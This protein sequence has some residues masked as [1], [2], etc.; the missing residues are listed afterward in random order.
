[1]KAPITLTIDESLYKKLHAHLFPGDHDEHGAVLACGLVETPRGTRLLARD[2]FLAKDGVDYIPGKRGYRALTAEFVARIS[3]Y[4]ARERLCYLAVHCHRG[5]DSVGFSTDDMNSHERGYPALL[6]ITEGG[7]VGALV[8]A[9]NAVAGDV[10]TPN[11]RHELDYM[12]VIGP[13]VR[14]LYPRPEARPDKVHLVYDRHAR[15]FGDA[16]Q[17]VLAGLKV[18]IVGLGGGGSLLSEWLARLGVGHIVG[19]DFDR[20]DITNLPRVVGAT[21]WDALALLAES[22]FPLLR[23]LAQ[24]Y[25]RHKVLVAK[26]VAKR[27]NPHIKYDAVVGDVLDESTA[28]LLRDADMIFLCTDNIL[29]RWAFNGLVHQFLIPGVQV[30]VKVRADKRTGVVGEIIAATRPVLPY[31]GGGCLECNGLIP[32]DRLTKETL[33]PQ[34]R[35]AHEYV[36]SADVTEPSVI[37]LNVLSAAQAANDLMMI[38]TGLYNDDVVIKPHIHFARERFTRIITPRSDEACPHCGVGHNSRRGRGDRAR[39]LTRMP[40]QCAAQT[41]RAA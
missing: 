32:A 28:S 29:S 24:R 20:L 3:D 17:Q 31:Q 25:A 26:R 40:T 22:R 8:F 14:R 13:R 30:G 41:R 5:H 36:E 39:M 1:M 15:L 37:T 16:G 12:T 11:G 2:L 4:C 18:V 23:R 10:R 35:K 21:R 19:V 33:S 7:P 38:F 34:E 6:D 9:H 27:A